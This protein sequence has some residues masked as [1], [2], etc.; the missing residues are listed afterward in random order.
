VAYPDRLL[1]DHESVVVDLHPHWWYFVRPTAMLVVAIAAGVAT[2]AMTEAGGTVRT[3][4]AWASLAAIAVSTVWV[5]A[6][7]VRWGSTHFVVTNQRIIFRSGL[8]VTRG[9]EIPLDRISTVHSSQGLGA[10]LVGAGELVIESGGES[11]R[12]HFTDIRHPGRVQREIHGQMAS[13]SGRGSDGSAIAFV[14]V[15]GQLEKLEAM[16]DRG[17]ITE[18]EFERQKR[19]LLGP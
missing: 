13:R 18:D 15:A 7:Y 9:V 1:N 16:L 2:I 14:D 6:R 19:R 12:Q 3:V 17:T 5:I 10:R 4:A 8:L 11:G